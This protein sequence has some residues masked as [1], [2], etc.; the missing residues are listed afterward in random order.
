M[1]SPPGSPRLT[2]RD[3]EI[4]R[5]LWY[6]PLTV[7]QLLKLS[8][9]FSTPFGTPRRLRARML[10]LVRAGWVRQWRYATAGPAASPAYYTLSPLGYRLL[11]G[12]KA[13]LP[14]PSVFLPVAIARQ[15]HTQGL[16]DFIIHTAVAGHKFG[17]VLTGFYRE[18]ALRLPVGGD[19]LSPDCAF[20]LHTP[21]GVA[22]SFFVELDNS[23]ETVRSEK[24]LDSWQRK[25]A[26][27]EAFQEQHPQRFRVVI[28]TTASSSRLGHILA[29]ARERL[30]NPSRRLFYGIALPAYLA[31]PDAVTA[32]CFL[33]H[34]NQRQAL[35]PTGHRVVRAATAAMAN[36]APLW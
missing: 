17:I 6:A 28:V 26:L 5:G 14:P 33:D 29:L 20:Q 9:T 13:P 25:V 18:N 35:V 30:H 2:P 8:A 1:P 19:S 10:L 36:V 34:H 15:H 21:G 22:Y 27:Y 12:P 24:S 16:A 3:L 11:Q 31:C 32:P 4:L 23:T 7:A